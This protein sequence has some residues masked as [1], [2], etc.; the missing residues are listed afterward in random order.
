M[1][2][3]RDKP[4]RRG[5]TAPCSTGTCVHHRQRRVKKTTTAS[6]PQGATTT[7]YL[8]D[9]N[10]RLL[11]ETDGTGNPRVTYVWR[12]D[13][14]TAVILAGPP[15]TLLYLET[16]HLDTPR[17]ARNAQKKIV[18][19]WESDAFGS[20]PANEDPDNDGN[21]TTIN[22]RFPGQYYDQESGMHYNWHRVYDPAV[23]RCPSDHQRPAGDVCKVSS[24]G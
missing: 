23:G 24:K 3:A 8:Y 5:P 11:V 21:K 9:P 14:P 15:E 19:R 18:W 6:A 10:D 20:S 7:H 1:F 17:L 22:L 4:C 16:D 2:R 13:V 12:D